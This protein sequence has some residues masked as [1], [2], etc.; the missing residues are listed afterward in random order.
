MRGI[1]AVVF[2]LVS[3]HMLAQN[4]DLPRE[5]AGDTL[6]PMADPKYR[7]DQFYASVTYNLM[8]G[9]PKGYSQYSVSTGVGFGFLRDMPLNKRRN[10]AIAIGLGYN[11]NNIKHNLVVSDSLGKTGY[12]VVSK[13]TFTRNKLV[14]HYLEIPIEYRWRTSNEVSH[15]FWRIYTGI[16]FSYLFY[17]KAK[18]YPEG[19]P[20]V[21]ITNDTNINRLAAGAYIAAGYNTWNFYAY[22]GLTPIYDSPVMDDGQKLR[23]HSLKL[24]LMFYIL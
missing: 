20:S 7:E 23:L 17:D 10:R 19:G 24:G 6:F 16:K 22:Y 13:T 8:Q 18:Y 11:Y 5:T 14:L 9:K 3:L 21:K 4:P 1:F 2:F 15:Q 12:N